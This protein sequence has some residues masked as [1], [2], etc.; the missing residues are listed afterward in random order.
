[1][2]RDPPDS[3]DRMCQLLPPLPPP[4]P[5]DRICLGAR[6]LQLAEAR[7]RAGRGRDRGG[8]G[9]RTANSALLPGSRRP[10]PPRSHP[11]SNGVAR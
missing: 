6:H 2:L 10:A 1:M 9:A 3:G 5:L 7:A 11:P 4:E 8:G